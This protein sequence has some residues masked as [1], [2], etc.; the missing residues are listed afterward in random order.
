MTQTQASAIIAELSG[1]AARA[2]EMTRD[3]EE[4]VRMTVAALRLAG[5]SWR[6]VGEA[7]GTSK[8]AAWERFG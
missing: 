5:A 1:L 7:L 6:D 8:Q 3:H 4:Y 2:Q